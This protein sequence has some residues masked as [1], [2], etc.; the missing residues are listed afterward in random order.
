MASNPETQPKKR[1]SRAGTR[2]VATLTTEQLERKRANDREAQRTIRL[3]TREHIDRLESQVAE[4]MAKGDQYEH[5]LRRNA[6]LEN[7]IRYLK[8]QLA[9]LSSGQG[10]SSAAPEGSYNAHP[11]S[12]LP[13]SQFTEPLGVNPVSRAPSALSTSSQVSVQ[14]D[15]PPYSTTG[16]PTIGESPD[17]DYS[18]RVEPFLFENSLQAPNPM[19]VAAPQVSFNAPNGPPPEP[20]LHSYPHLHVGSGSH[21]SRREEHPLNPQHA[22]QFASSHRSMSVPSIPLDREVRGYPILPGA[23]QYAQPPEQPPRNEYYEWPRRS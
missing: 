8:H 18:N 10:F 22:L 12:I 2:K 19:A 1:E 6:E 5:V 16:S 9:L 23:Q 20:P 15:W 3:R 21:Q 11:G 7:E 14:H 17:A 4:L 13:S